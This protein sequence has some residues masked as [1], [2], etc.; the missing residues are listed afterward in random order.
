[1]DDDSFD[2]A[3]IAAAFAVA[4]RD[5][6]NAVS[7]AAAA[8][9]AGLPLPRARERFPGPNAILLRF[10]RLADQAALTGA[11]TD[12]T[13]REKLFDVL[14]RRFDA[15]QAHRDGVRALMRALPANPPLALILGAAT[16]T[17]MGWMLEGA[18]MSSTGVR[19]ALRAKGLTAVWLF[20]LRAWQR[21]DSPDLSG[22]MA[23]LDR[24][25]ARAEEFGQWLEG[26]RLDGGTT[27][28]GP[29][30]F[31]EPSTGPFPGDP[32]AAPPSSPA[33]A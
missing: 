17:S 7:V 25:L 21:D 5:G 33:T 15:L 6:W 2:R 32:P 9:D 3:L 31:P 19:G 27:P 23:A 14:M 13:P 12:G 30:P 24:A 4:A 26:G 1:M 8:H 10:G 20:V 11:A 16:N 29:K 18:G 28:S 22:T